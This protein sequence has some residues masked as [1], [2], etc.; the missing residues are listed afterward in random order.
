VIWRGKAARHVAAA[1]ARQPGKALAAPGGWVFLVNDTNDFLPWQFGITRWTGGERDQVA[2]TL[3]ARLEALAPTPYLM[4]ITPEK[5]VAYQEYLPMGLAELRSDPSR[6]ATW[7]AARFPA[8]VH[9][10]QPWFERMKRLGFLYF[11]GDTH[12]NWLGGYLVYRFV[13]EALD[14]AG[15]KT[16]PAV[17]SSELLPNRAGFEGDVFVQLDERQRLEFDIDADYARWRAMLEITIK[18]DMDQ[19]QVRAK[20]VALTPEDQAG[21]HGRDLLI[22]EIPDSDLPRAVVFRDS[23]ATDSIPFLAEHFSRSVY[24]WH[25]G[26]VLAEI[27][28]REQPDVVLHFVAE[29]FL[30]T[31]PTTLPLNFAA[32]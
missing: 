21:F 2:A 13:V 32:A 7:M 25:E 29:R 28:R 5:S 30:A 31:Y 18:Y 11:R 15:V 23:T 9:Y 22:Y 10:L 17:T 6:P 1:K 4:F 16:R 27:I 3:K 19:T 24:V 12:V 8:Q 20:R 14:K 26:D